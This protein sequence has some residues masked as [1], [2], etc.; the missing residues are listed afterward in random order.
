MY[1]LAMSTAALSMSAGDTKERLGRCPVAHQQTWFTEETA[2]CVSQ[3]RAEELD[4]ARERFSRGKTSAL[5][6]ANTTGCTTKLPQDGMTSTNYPHD[7]NV[8]RIFVR[9]G[10]RRPFDNLE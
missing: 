1:A 5:D 7:G 9:E 4:C 8:E 6:C 3:G 2:E 10:D